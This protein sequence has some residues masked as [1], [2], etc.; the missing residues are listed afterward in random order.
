MSPVCL[1]QTSYASYETTRYL[2]LSRPLLKSFFYFPN[3]C[4]QVRSVAPD[5]SGQWLLSGSDDGTA[6]LWEVRRFFCPARALAFCMCL[7]F[8]CSTCM[9]L[10]FA[11]AASAQMA[12][13][14][15][16]VS[17]KHCNVS[18]KS[19]QDMWPM[20]VWP[21][22]A[23]PRCVVNGHFNVSGKHC[24]MSGKHGRFCAWM[25]CPE[26][27]NEPGNEHKHGHFVQLIAHH[28]TR[29]KS[30]QASCTYACISCLCHGTSA[31]MF[32]HGPSSAPMLSRTW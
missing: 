32:T 25:H 7:A 30:V 15:F 3:S 20:C 4:D 22:C 26:S 14:H 9:C 28:L 31:P 12:N 13:G 18:G 16:T 24:N 8:A 21:M 27:G 6:K 11:Y 10:A 2:H 5:A 1:L 19:W 17:G 23:W 29:I